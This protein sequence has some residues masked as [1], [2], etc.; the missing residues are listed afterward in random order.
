[1]N[2]RMVIM[3]LSVAAALTTFAV[4]L[5]VDWTNELGP[6]KPVNGVG[7][8]PM[9]GAPAEFPLM[10]YLKDAG[11]PYSRL[12][13]VGGWFGGNLYVDIPNLFP[14]FDAD[15]ND[16]ANYLFDATDALMKALRANQIE[17]IFRLGVTIENFAGWDMGFK[18]R[19]IYPP[20]DYAKWARICEHV[21]RHY[22][23]G[24]AHGMKMKITYW[25]IW[26][27]PENH[28]IIKKN[29]MWRAPFEEYMKFYGVV[30]PYL[31][32]KFP[33]LKFGGYGSCGF[34][35]P[36]TKRGDMDKVS[37]KQINHFVTCASNFLASAKKENW[38]LDFFS[39]HS[40]SGV[41]Q[42]LKEVEFADRL[43]TDHGFPREKCLRVFDE[44]LPNP[45]LMY[46]GTAGQAALV[47]AEMI[48]LQNGPCDIACIYDARCKVSAYTPLFNALTRKP[49]KAYQ[50][51]MAFKALRDC[52]T[53]VATEVKGSQKLY[54]AAAKGE[55]GAAVMI[56]NTTGDGVA[57]TY[58]FQ[59]R[60]VV[61]VRL[62]DTQHTNEVVPLPEKIPAK[63]ILLVVLD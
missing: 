48:G 41:G 46:S 47:A 17:P 39:F 6:V 21:I 44:W 59:G 20:K 25:E 33:H 42:A 52:G 12:H 62:T 60:K 32:S 43:L 50:A 8:P 40:Y 34:E 2:K 51:F 15:E 61:E 58:D 27:E 9:I 19:R 45:K 5:K 57:T 18:P 37:W 7:Q 55:K 24:W 13:D 28:Y 11:I 3:S 54:A 1:M 23:E 49:Y 53:A 30:T 10:H 38:P 29:P 16:P 56:A 31:K 63:S 35:A 26:N 22:T 36:F 4:E 14:N